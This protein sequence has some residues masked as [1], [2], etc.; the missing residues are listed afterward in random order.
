MSDGR[1]PDA[2]IAGPV[3][4]RTASGTT[5]LLDPNS[6]TVR[7]LRGDGAG[8]LRRDDEPI[9]LQQWPTPV[10]GRPMVL[11]LQL[12]DDH[13]Q[14]VRMTTPVQAIAPSGQ[15]APQLNTERTDR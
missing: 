10:I 1:L 9:P 8:E 14:T 3:C 4:V 2:P 13:L 11:V 6:F 5:Y 12:R 15:A 7:R